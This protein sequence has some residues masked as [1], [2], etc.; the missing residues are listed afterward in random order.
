MGPPENILAA[1]VSGRYNSG[2]M[3]IEV[4]YYLFA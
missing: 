2:Y 1:L 4:I 3:S